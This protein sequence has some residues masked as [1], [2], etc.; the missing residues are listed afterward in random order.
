MTAA[1]KVVDFT[2]VKD[3][4]G[5]NPVQQTPGDYKAKITKVADHKSHA[6]NEGWVFSIVTPG[7]NGRATYPYYCTIDEK[8]LWKVRNLFIAA[9]MAVPKK[10]VKV[11]P[12]KLVGKVIGI[13]LDDDEYEGKMKSQIV[14]TFPADELDGDSPDDAG[15]DGADTDGDTTDTDEDADVS[16]DE[17]EDLDV[18][19]L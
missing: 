1:V 10:R 13:S 18:D 11:D 19:E 15:D 7:G 6:G 9:G 16:D 4:G 3:G 8:S 5:F 2:N 17:L 14:A 12:N